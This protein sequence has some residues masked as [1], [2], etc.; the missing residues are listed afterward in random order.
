M[1]KNTLLKNKWQGMQY[2]SYIL[3]V[4]LISGLLWYAFSHD[5]LYFVSLLA[6]IL[7]SF[8]EFGAGI[9]AKHTSTG[10]EGDFIKTLMIYLACIT[11]YF[12]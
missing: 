7:R 5:F 10:R 4:M 2:G 1:L 9:H 3:M 6:E 12:R 8:G 11:H